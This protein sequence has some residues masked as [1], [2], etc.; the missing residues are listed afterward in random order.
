M[1]EAQAGMADGKKRKT[2]FIDY[3]FVGPRVLPH[4]VFHVVASRPWRC[5]SFPHSVKGDETDYRASRWQVMQQAGLGGTSET[6]PSPL[7]MALGTL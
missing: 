1:G 2:I 7:S 6:V 4:V 3:G 5:L